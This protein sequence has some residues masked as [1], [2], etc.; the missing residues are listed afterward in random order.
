MNIR[1][2]EVQMCSC[3]PKVP[4]REFIS[5]QRFILF[6]GVSRKTV[7]IIMSVALWDNALYIIIFLSAARDCTPLK[8]VEL[9]NDC[10][11]FE[12]KTAMCTVKC[13]V[14]TPV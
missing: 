10:N 6:F 11:G 2:R 3:L 5:G 12:F 9:H 1:F 7:W 8:S 13:K 14:G 4:R